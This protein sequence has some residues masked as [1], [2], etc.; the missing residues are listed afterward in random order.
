M[1]YQLRIT[2][3]ARRGVRA[4]VV[5]DSKMDFLS[6]HYYLEGL[7]ALEAGGVATFVVI[8]RAGGRGIELTLFADDGGSE[9][10]RPMENVRI[11]EYVEP[12]GV[13][14]DYA[15]GLFLDKIVRIEVVDSYQSPLRPDVP[16]CVAMRGEFRF[17]DADPLL[18]NL[19]DIE[20]L[21]RENENFEGPAD[22][23]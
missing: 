7:L 2:D 14:F 17:N 20:E 8:D 3:P 1:Q 9:A 21:L 16:V 5:V 19:D 4:D 22:A 23:E 12:G 10:Q 13:C 18:R 11:E 6:L 15:F